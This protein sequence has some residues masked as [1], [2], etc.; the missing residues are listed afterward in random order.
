MTLFDLPRKPALGNLPKIKPL[1]QLLVPNSHNEYSDPNTLYLMGILFLIRTN[2]EPTNCEPTNCQIDECIGL[3]NW[4]FPSINPIAV[5][6]G[7]PPAVSR[8][9]PK[10]D[11]AKGK[12]RIPV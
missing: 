1:L 6:T 3:N 2:Y 9:P 10:V 4:S 7:D 8:H 5:F 11:L 12:V